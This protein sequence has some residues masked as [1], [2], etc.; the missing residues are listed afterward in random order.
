[1]AENLVR[2]AVIEQVGYR[3]W[4]ESL[5]DDREWMIQLVQ[6]RV[7]RAGQEAAAKVDGFL[8]P[9][10]FDIMLLLASNLRPGEVGEVHRAI[11]SASEVPV[12][13]ASA[14][15]STPLGA[16]DEAWRRLRGL[17]PGSWFFEP[18]EGG[19]VSA[20]AHIDINGITG[21]TRRLGPLRTYYMV[22]DTLARIR[23]RGEK[24]GSIVQYLG[25]D[26]LLA[27]LPPGVDPTEAVE[28]LII[29]EGRGE[30]LKAG[31]GLALKP[32]RS[33]ALAAKALHK[34]R[35]GEA[36]GRVVVE[37]SIET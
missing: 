21:L 1:M 27:V 8:L 13:T 16:V 6:S 19:E 33:L 9:I 37:S 28:Y 3:E 14:C 23:L 4:T 12:R 35:S 17:E 11:A 5:G 15:H 30:D 32:R 10:R 20:V 31:V 34:I 22:I 24:M 25:G 7:Y 18:C 36:A 29:E 26:N 2:V